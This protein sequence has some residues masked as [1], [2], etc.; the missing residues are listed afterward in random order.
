MTTGLS[1]H[2]ACLRPGT[3]WVPG[4]CDLNHG[5]MCH[6]KSSTSSEQAEGTSFWTP[7][8]RYIMGLKVIYP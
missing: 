6:V 1:M 5:V 4:H 2:D 8:S 7:Q 3:A